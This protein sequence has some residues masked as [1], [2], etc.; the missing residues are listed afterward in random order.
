MI[1][2]FR[3][4]IDTIKKNFKL[5]ALTSA[6]GQT[7]MEKTYK[8]VINEMMDSNLFKFIPGRKSSYT[9]IDAF[10]EGLSIMNHEKFVAGTGQAEADDQT[11]DI[12]LDSDDAGI[13]DSV[14]DM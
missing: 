7:G 8:A 11:D 14:E 5:T 12:A 9:I 3:G 13:L 1:H 6:H 2:I 10:D 4:V